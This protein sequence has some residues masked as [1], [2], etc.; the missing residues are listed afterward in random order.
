MPIQ[1]PSAIEI[2][3]ALDAGQLTV[4]QHVA[5]LVE[6][7]R[8]W[9]HLNSI[10]GFDE[11]QLLRT[12]RERTAERARPGALGRLHGVPFV[13]KDN[14]DTVDLP[15][16]ACTPALRGNRPPRNAPVLQRLLDAGALLFGKANM[17]ELAFGITNNHGAFGA[18][19]NPYDPSCI[20][21]GSSGGSAAAVAAGIVPF[22]LGSDTGGSVRIPAALCGVSGLRPTLGRYSQDGI[23]PISPTRDTAGPIARS[24]ADLAL[25]D[26][27]ISGES[28]AL[29]GIELHRLRIGVPREYFY[30]NLEPAVATAMEGF[31]AALRAAGVTLVEESIPDVR[32]LDEAVSFVVVNREARRCLEKYLAQSAPGVSFEDVI[33]QIASPDVKP[34]YE[35]IANLDLVPENVYRET[36]DVHRPALQG[37]FADYFRRHRLDAYLVP[38]CCMTARPIGQD[39][40]VDLNGQQVPT[41]LSFI[42][43]ADP[44][45]NAGIPGVSI[46]IGRSEA[47]L[48]IGAMIESPAGSDRRLLAIAQEFAR[49][50]GPIAPP[51]PGEVDRS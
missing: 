18:A 4:E 26:G 23:V 25:V 21:G 47:G 3:A 9:R 15:T 40:T 49:M 5:T 7:L 44:A 10:V 37:A 48:P 16:T 22:A 35:A 43:N 11:A 28:A 34:V 39:Q 29:P 1:S 2:L 36:L 20:P 38:T 32:K 31:L 46:P 13:A 27:V 45:S 30:E 17:H 19:R 33:R 24:V 14:I 42:R 51:T 8:Q 41:F 6:R 50:A 12:A